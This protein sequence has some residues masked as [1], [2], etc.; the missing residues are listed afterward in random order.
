[1]DKAIQK[2]TSDDLGTLWRRFA[3]DYNTGFINFTYKNYSKWPSPSRNKTVIISNNLSFEKTFTMPPYSANSIDIYNGNKK[4]DYDVNISLSHAV[5]V[6][7][8]FDAYIYDQQGKQIMKVDFDGQ[9][10]T[11]LVKSGG[12]NRRTAILINSGDKASEVKL[13]IKCAEIENKVRSSCPLLYDPLLQDPMISGIPYIRIYPDSQDHTKFIV[14]NYYEDPVF[15][16]ITKFSPLESSMPYVG[17]L[18]NGIYIDYW[19][20]GDVRYTGLY[21]NDKKE[22]V[23]SSYTYLYTGQR[24]LWSAVTFKNDEKVAETTYD[25]KDEWDF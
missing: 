12:E 3:M 25:C 13:K 24:C 6:D 21:V 14:C 11:F 15:D 20:T 22:G 19:E 18:K 5:G 1:M 16:Q 9:P 7:Y 8:A 2:H 4:I 17:N 10:K 23:F